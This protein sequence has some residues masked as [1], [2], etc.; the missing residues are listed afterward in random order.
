MIV[1]GSF[2]LQ[3]RWGTF[4]DDYSGNIQF[5]LLA[6]LAA[7]VPPAA[8]DAR[9]NVLIT[10]AELTQAIQHFRNA[11]GE[12]DLTLD[13]VIPE[14]AIRRRRR[15]AVIPPLVDGVRPTLGAGATG[16]YS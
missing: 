2:A 9:D 14:A 8:G 1:D 10:D 4:D 13:V 7:A 16:D 3:D 5:V 15:V 11:R 6:E 12:A